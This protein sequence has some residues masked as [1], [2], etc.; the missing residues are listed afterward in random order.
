MCQ[1]AADR[2]ARLARL[3]GRGEQAGYWADLA[4]RIRETLLR[5]AY[6][7]TA[8]HFSEHLGVD[9]VTV[10][11][12]LLA[13]PLRRVVD[14]AD[15][16]MRATVDAVRDRLGAGGGLLYRYLPAESPDGLRGEEGAFLLCSF[17]WADNLVAGGR[18]EQGR[19]LFESLCARVNHVG[20]LAEQV[21]PTTG[22]FLGNF[23]QAFSHIGLI[24]TAV[25]LACHTPSED[26]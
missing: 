9:E 21:D 19:E 10:D 8:G 16:R 14:A 17:W 26:T 1:V 13:L 24:S 2:T 25:N 15:P 4:G 22:A 23:P 20:L 11:S 5:D 12:S 3:T 7:P 18:L 6:N